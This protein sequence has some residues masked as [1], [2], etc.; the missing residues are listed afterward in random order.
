M[1][2][3]HT[4]KFKKTNNNIDYLNWLILIVKA[5]YVGGEKQVEMRE[6][7]KGIHCTD[8]TLSM[9]GA[10]ISYSIWELQG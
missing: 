2:N 7:E 10:R 8:K 9:G 4:L 1:I 5:K 3:L 6:L